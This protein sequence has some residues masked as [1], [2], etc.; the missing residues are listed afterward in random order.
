MYAMDNEKILAK[1]IVER[2]GLNEPFLKYERFDGSSFKEQALVSTHAEALKL[3]CAKLVERD[4][5][6]LNSLKDVE[7]IGH[8][9]VHGGENF[10]DSVIVTNEVKNNIHE[11]AA[12]APLHNPPNLGGIEACQLVFDGIPNVAVFDTAFHHSMPA[13]SYLYA[14]PYDYYEKFGIRKYGFHGTSHKFVSYA[15]AELLKAP[16]GELKLITAHLGNGASITAVERGNVLDT[17]MGM[18]PL[19]GLVM[20]TRCG[21]IDPAVVLYLARRGMT[22]DAIDKL[23][24]KC[25]GLLG[26][27]GIGS[28]DMRDNIAAAEAG[29]LQAQR[30][31]RMFV[32]RL[33]SYVG[34]YFT[35]LNGADA[36]VFTGG[37][38]E[39]S[40]YIREQTV[41]KLESLGCYLDPQK[42]NQAIG[43]PAIISTP[44]SKLKAIVMPTNEELMIARETVRLL[45]IPVKAIIP[46]PACIAN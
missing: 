24:N 29:N 37:I 21:D 23:L 43:R 7:A 4:V 27:S 5:G 11:C 44:E 22:P 18:T 40:S 13:S 15:T 19:N 34:S 8:R 6:V 1:G 9:V 26:V 38:G 16:L 42:N 3:V 28:G 30:G 17:S 32:Q 31:I 33:V 36:V 14:I 41:R 12:L 39:N 25:S 20:G 2:I 10:H 45:S 46:C 35:L